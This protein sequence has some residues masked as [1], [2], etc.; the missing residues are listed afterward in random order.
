MTQV[1]V[2][3]DLKHQTLREPQGHTSG[4]DPVGT[5]AQ[6]TLTSHLKNNREIGMPKEKHALY[7]QEVSP[8]S[9]EV[10]K[11]RPSQPGKAVVEQAPLV[12][13]SCFKLPD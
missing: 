2:L 3:I 6:Q 10:C 7:Q 13:P 4:G 8:P 9:R 11:H 1:G 12:H 5:G